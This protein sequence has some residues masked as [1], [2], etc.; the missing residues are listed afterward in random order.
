MI[1]NADKLQSV[2]KNKNE[3]DGPAFKIWDDPRFTKIGK[4]LSHTGLD[5]LPQLINILKGDMNF[6]GPRPL[7]IYEYKKID[8]KYKKRSLVKPGILS[9][10]VINGY[11]KNTFSDWMNSDLNYVKEKSWSYDFKILQKGI[12]LIFILFIKEIKNIKH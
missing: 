12:C 4:F 8:L 10:W 9:P 6:I 1:K 11:H 5:E 2:Y 7:P 3:V